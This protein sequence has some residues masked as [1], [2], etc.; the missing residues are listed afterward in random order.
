M[1]SSWEDRVRDGAYVS[2]S[3]ARIVYQYED[4]GRAVALRTAVFGFPGV[5]G[6]YVQ[7]NG[8]GSRKY[9]LRCYFSGRRHDIEATLFEAALLEKG[10]GK[11]EHPFYGTVTVVPVGEIVR[12]DDLKT[13]ANQTVVDVEFWT[14]L[15]TLYP[16]ALADPENEI[17]AAL[18]RFN[19]GAAQQF[20]GLAKLSKTVEKAAAKGTIRGLLSEISDVLSVPAKLVASVNHEFQDLRDTINYGIDVLIGQ[21]L[22][23][24]EQIKDLITA[25]ARALDGIISRIDAYADLAGRIFG[26]DA[27]DPVAS[28]AAVPEAAAGKFGLTVRT[29]R[30]ANDFHIADMVAAQCV[31]GT[32]IAALQSTTN[33]TAAGVSAATTGTA[34]TAST[35]VVGVSGDSGRTFLT[36]PKAIAAAEAVVASFDAFVDWRDAGFAALQGVEKT[37]T[38]QVDPGEA[39]GQL[40]QAA[41][42]A[43]GHIV[44]VSFSLVPERVVVL[45]RPRT[46]VDL[47]GELYGQVDEAEGF[48]PL[49]YMIETNDL[50]GDEIQELPRGKKITYYKAA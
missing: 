45:D 26:S 1:A 33:A 50:N 19:A 35:G 34:A 11:L 36:R 48:D 18:A 43:A 15:T 7:Q 4:V 44:E 23:L 27:G 16:Q 9:P 17:L 32:I 46:I 20:A 25:P 12:R 28:L 8:F 5:D 6:D 10:L 13:A 39:V 38:Y 22:L 47:C 41:A 3:G 24:A 30:V 29:Q 14:T 2:P 49:W 37:G 42:M 31:A 40:Q 21:P